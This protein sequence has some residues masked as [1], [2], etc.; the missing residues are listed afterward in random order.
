MP[1][2]TLWNGARGSTTVS[3]PSQTRELEEVKREIE[4]SLSDDPGDANEIKPKAMESSPGRDGPSIPAAA[5][6]TLT[7]ACNATAADIENSGKAVVELAKGIAA[8]GDALAELLRKHGASITT[9][10]EHFTAVTK[11]IEAAVKEVRADL[12]SSTVK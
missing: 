4:E 3:R 12:G 2:S 5:T 1:Y 10:I 6:R 8:E 7:D 9:K 11:Q